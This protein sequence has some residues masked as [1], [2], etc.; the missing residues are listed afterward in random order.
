MKRKH[1]DIRLPHAYFNVSVAAFWLEIV[2]VVHSAVELVSYNEQHS[3]YQ[4]G[5]LLY[6]V[7]D[8]FPWRQ[9]K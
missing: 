4:A 7:S 1:F 5:Y 2:F 9:L 3:G 6:E 8:L